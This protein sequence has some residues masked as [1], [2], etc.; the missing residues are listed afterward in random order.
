MGS[1]LNL[2][3]DTGSTE[4]FQKY[5]IN[6]PVKFYELIVTAGKADPLEY[7]SRDG[8]LKWP[9]IVTFVYKNGVEETEEHVPDSIT[10]TQ[11]FAST[12]VIRAS[13]S[14][15]DEVAYIYVTFGIYDGETGTR[16]RIRF[17]LS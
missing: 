3:A 11:A 15:M 10:T 5:V 9:D 4:S 17:N 2:E 14:H 16:W 6:V 7:W 12:W 1:I 13:N 8:T